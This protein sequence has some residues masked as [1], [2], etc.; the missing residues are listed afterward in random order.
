MIFKTTLT[1]NTFVKNPIFSQKSNFPH[2]G[3]QNTQIKQKVKEVAPSSGE[4]VDCS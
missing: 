3:S 1:E 2:V 4:D